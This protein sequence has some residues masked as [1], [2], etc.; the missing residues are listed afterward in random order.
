MTPLRHKI[1]KPLRDVFLLLL[2]VAVPLACLSGLAYGSPVQD[3]STK[4]E[5]KTEDRISDLETYYLKRKNGEIVPYFDFAFSE[6][7]EIFKLYLGGKRPGKR[8][9]IENVAITGKADDRVAELDIKLQVRTIQDGWSSTPLD[10]GQIILRDTKSSL[11]KSDYLISRTDDGL[12]LLLNG[13]KGMTFSF[14]F[15]GIRSLKKKGARRE[16]SL[17]IPNS[18]YSSLEIFVDGKDLVG[19]ASDNADLSPVQPVK[20]NQTKFFV[21]KVQGDFQLNWIP[22]TDSVKQKD[23]FASNSTLKLRLTQD[24]IELRGEIKIDGFGNLVPGFELKLPKG[25]RLADVP[26]NGYT[27]IPQSLNVNAKTQQTAQVTFDEL[28]DRPPSVTFLATSSAVANRR[29]LDLTGFEIAGSQRHKGTIEITAESDVQYR[30]LPNSNLARFVSSESGTDSRVEIYRFFSQPVT[31]KIALDETKTRIRTT[32]KYQL[33][34]TQSELKVEAQIDYRTSGKP[35]TTLEFDCNGWEVRTV[36]PLRLIE[37]FDYDKQKDKLIVQLLDVAQSN[38]TDYRIQIEAIKPISVQDSGTQT[39]FTVPS[40]TI[41]APS[42]C[43]IVLLDSSKRLSFPHKQTLGFEEISN[44]GS[45]F[46]S[47][48]KNSDAGPGLMAYAFREIGSTN[49]SQL[50]FALELKD[51]EL[52]LENRVTAEY[53][54][55][56]EDILLG[57]A[58]DMEILYRPIKELVLAVDSSVENDLTVTMDSEAVQFEKVESPKSEKPDRYSLISLKLD[59]AVIGNHKIEI[60]YRQPVETFEDLDSLVSKIVVPGVLDPWKTDGTA[61]EAQLQFGQLMEL[62]ILSPDTH[63][64]KIEDGFVE[65]INTS[66]LQTFAP[67]GSF[68]NEIRLSF[69]KK[70]SADNTRMIH[71]LWCQTTLSGQQRFERVIVHVDSSDDLLSLSLPNFAKLIT[72]K[73]NGK[74][75]TQDLRYFGRFDLDIRSEQA[76]SRVE[77]IYALP[78]KSD[79]S[80]NFSTA[81]PRVEGAVY[82]QSFRWEL[83]CPKDQYFLIPDAALEP[84]L[85]WKW[86]GLM[87]VR[88]SNV[89]ESKIGRWIQSEYERVDL[90][91]CNRYSFS[92]FGTYKNYTI[93]IIRRRELLILSALIIFG[94]GT[95]FLTIKYMRSP[96]SIMAIVIG[97]FVLSF[98]VTDLVAFIAQ[99][100]G[101]VL[102]LALLFMI[103]RELLTPASSRSLS[104]DV[105]FEDHGSSIQNLRFDSA[106]QQATGSQISALTDRNEG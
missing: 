18:T 19:E 2:S 58:I 77:L 17:S 66:T 1:M 49:E 46:E 83:I 38:L 30:L 67:T 33:C 10:F 42:I 53:F 44:S 45:I 73:I 21:Q 96:L 3:E 22:K 34:I 62:R 85:G 69:F 61:N 72:A 9:G 8:F 37:S 76:R 54:P 99:I 56:S 43:Q 25:F 26:T 32:P 13:K 82:V 52:N 27:L 70:L 20:D 23:E 51:G 28:T 16:L 59:Q 81:L 71:K 95:S 87:F 7:E 102:G 41:M 75:I 5:R 86:N 103:F 47:F 89:D 79:A 105:N 39:A 74:T 80:R 90:K 40:Q 60:S 35:L 57:S 29:Q 94:I 97:L 98:R 63:N 93:T 15:Q 36:E 14:N 92:A 65:E 12:E 55:D 64:A 48:T 4:P 106:S 11:D 50:E 24:V 78:L 91:T 88:Q 104:T 31:M 6:F 101:V 84:L 68:P 100:G